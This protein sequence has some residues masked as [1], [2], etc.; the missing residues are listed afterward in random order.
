MLRKASA[1]AIDSDPV[2][3]S[4]TGAMLD[5]SNLAARVVKPA[6]R[7]AGVEWAAFHTLRH[8]CATE[9]FR[10]GLNAK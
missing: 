2:F 1:G 8:T 10:R 6:A 7:A 4:A 9:L 5:P 3:T